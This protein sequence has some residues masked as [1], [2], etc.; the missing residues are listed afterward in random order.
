MRL[1]KGRSLEDSRLSLLGALLKTL[2][3]ALAASKSAMAAQILEN[4]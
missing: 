1:T 2:T 3:V 4:P